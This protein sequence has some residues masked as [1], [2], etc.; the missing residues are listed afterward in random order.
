MVWAL[1]FIEHTPLFM[2]LIVLA[3]TISVAVLISLK[4]STWGGLVIV[5]VVGGGVLVL[6]TYFISLSSKIKAGIGPWSLLGLFL[7]LV[8][9]WWLPQEW[10]TLCGLRASVSPSLLSIVGRPLGLGLIRGLFVVILIVTKTV[11]QEA[12]PLRGA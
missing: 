4:V 10:I 1:L 5:V 11:K 7:S 6:Y 8:T 12:G 9:F 3:V 2:G